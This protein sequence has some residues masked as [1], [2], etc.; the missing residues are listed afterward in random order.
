MQT[1]PVHSP[2]ATPP[3]GRSRIY[4]CGCG[5]YH[6]SLGPLTLDLSEDELILLGR[7]VHEMAAK[8]PELS[9]RLATSLYQDHFLRTAR[10]KQD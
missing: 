7:T 4:Y 3:F 2:P 9:A 6:L 10:A 1:S 8:R 5:R